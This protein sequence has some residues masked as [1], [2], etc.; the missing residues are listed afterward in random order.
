MNNENASEVEQTLCKTL[1]SLKPPETGVLAFEFKP[2]LS[3]KRVASI[4]VKVHRHVNG[5]VSTVCFDESFVYDSVFTLT[6]IRFARIGFIAAML[7]IIDAT[8]I[9]QCTSHKY[10]S[11]M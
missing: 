4:N 1:I 5:S 2:V 11:F 9:I 10:F 8:S 3:E 7:S 6:I